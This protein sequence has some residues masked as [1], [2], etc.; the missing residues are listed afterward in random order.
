MEDLPD[1]GLPEVT[2]DTATSP[3]APFTTSLEPP[4]PPLAVAAR[5]SPPPPP[6]PAPAAISSL[7]PPPPP[8]PPAAPAAAPPAVP[9]AVPAPAPPAD[10]PRSGL[11]EAIR[12]AGGTSGAGLKSLNE[13]KAE[14]RARR[15]AEVETAGGA[16]ISGGDLMGD[17]M[18]KLNMRRKGISGAR[19]NEPEPAT[20]PAGAMDKISLMI[21]P[22][23]GTAEQDSESDDDGG[24]D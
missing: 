9:P 4:P 19:N 18:S 11:L 5:A 13:R 12:N 16:A 23:P 10:S 8:A 20:Q 22:P 3:P 15:E 7:P 17:L 14:E 24:W 2:E 6:P 1:I 21:P